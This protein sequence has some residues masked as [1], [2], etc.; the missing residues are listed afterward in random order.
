MNLNNFS[1]KK[2]LFLIAFLIAF[3][4]VII[5]FTTN[6]YIK[7]SFSQFDLLMKIDEVL[8]V[9]L[10]LRKAEKD[11]L[12]RE[13]IN[14]DFFKFGK[15]PSTVQFDSISRKAIELMN[16]LKVNKL[17]EGNAY[18]D[19]INSAIVL[20]NKYN[21][22]FLKING[23]TLEK[24][25]KDYGIEGRLRQAIHNVEKMLN[26]SS[27]YRFSTYMLTL[28]RHEKDYLLRKEIKYKDRFWEVLEIFT[29]EIRKQENSSRNNQII[30]SLRDY[31]QLFNLLIEKEQEIG[32]N[33]NDALLKDLKITSEQFETQLKALHSEI[34]SQSKNAIQLAILTL[35]GLII[36]ISIIA[37][38]I[39]IWVASHIVISIRKLRGFVIRLGKGELPDEMQIDGQNEITQMAESINVLTENLK[40]TREFAVEVGNGNLETE[41][42]VFGNQGDLGGALIEMRK[43]LL[44]V[45]R[46][47][48][49]QAQETQERLWANEGMALFAQVLGRR[50]MSIE[51]LAFDFIKNLVKY[52]KSNQAGLFLIDESNELVLTAA[53]A[54]ERRKFLKKKL[55]IN[56]GLVGMCYLEA[57]TTYLTDIP[58]DYMFITSGMGQASP[59]SLILVPLKSEDEVVGVVEMASLNEYGPSEIKFIDNV[60]KTAASTISMVRVRENTNALLEKTKL[61]AEILSEHEEELRQNIEE[62][63]AT[64]EIMT[65]RER[66]L[67][68]EIE[69][70]KEKL[71]S[72]KSEFQIELVR[73]KAKQGDLEM[74]KHTIDSS[75]I[76]LEVASDGSI[77]KA[78]NNFYNT[79]KINT[80]DEHPTIFDG[81]LPGQE[82][83]NRKEWSRILKGESFKGII[84]RIDLSGNH[85]AIQA[86]FS[87][88]MDDLEQEVRKVICIGQK[89]GLVGTIETNIANGN[90]YKD[91]IGSKGLI[92]DSEVN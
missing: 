1:I 27:D 88:H 50:D 60:I 83:Q 68:D 34:Y 31:G 82:N 58:V 80:A 39:I 51:D 72:I 13:T 64:Q 29:A 26:E 48:D 77:L 89:V 30:A 78:N 47:R 59:R 18:G 15:G 54:Y 20:L 61:Q 92:I 5:G 12:L 67:L 2:L 43:K 28:R 14:P 45:S 65:M 16:S 69:A 32:L 8:R 55:A 76:V 6:H 22:I 90:W 37:V 81:S 25:F 17:V 70:Y 40:Y 36:I 79:I 3:V 9:E 75:F 52:T 21:A 85:I 46:E 41:V 63:H 56:E 33:E 24:G 86:V 42:N 44:Q 19:E 66:E 38:S 11:F 53:Y 23:L 4:L 73:V 49:L 10:Q 71:A 74:L 87:P 7:K 35:F 62:M 91:F 57:E 84:H